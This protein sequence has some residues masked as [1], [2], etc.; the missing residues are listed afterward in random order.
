MI[1]AHATQDQVLA[2]PCRNGLHIVGIDYGQDPLGRLVTIGSLELAN[3]R[4]VFETLR[5]SGADHGDLVVDLIEDGQ[6]QDNFE[7]A[8]EQ[9]PQLM[10]AL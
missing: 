6:V 3:A 4:R 10:A 8:A 1:S 9:L 5:H 7:I 2:P